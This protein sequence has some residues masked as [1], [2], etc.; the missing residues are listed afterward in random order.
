MQADFVKTV[1]ITVPFEGEDPMGLEEISLDVFIDPRT[2]YY[3][4][5]EMDWTEKNS[6]LFSPFNRNMELDLPK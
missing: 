2:G 3:F 6:K 1:K 5:T 4:A